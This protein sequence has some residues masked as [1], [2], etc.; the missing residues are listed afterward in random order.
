[1]HLPNAVVSTVMAA[2]YGVLLST[3]AL[4]KT[5]NSCKKKFDEKISSYYSES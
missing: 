5:S 2:K 1:V 4:T 3:V